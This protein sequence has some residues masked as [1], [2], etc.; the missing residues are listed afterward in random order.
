VSGEFNGRIAVVTG[1][2]QGIGRAI[3]LDLARRG[4]R[5]QA[6]ARNREALAE[7][8]AL[9]ARDGGA[10]VPWECDVAAA[11]QIARTAGGILAAEGKVDFL[12]NNAGVTRDGLLLRMKDA[13]WDAVI[14]TNL[15]AAFRLCRALLPSMIRAR[16]GR[17]VNISSVV[18]AAGNPGQANYAASKAG[19]LGFTRALARE[20]ASRQVTVNAVAPG[21]IETAMTA[22]LPAQAREALLGQIPLGTLGTPEDI[23]AGVRYLVGEG[24]RYITGQVLHI[25]GG[26]YMA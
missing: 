24:G 14:G 6:L 16:F 3:A 22:V 20:V 10:V 19:L 15:T 8:A 5:V 17:M 12:V 4:A 1:A 25:N 23:A 2:S 13:D 26:M 18:A 21:Y 9:A 7:T 11:E